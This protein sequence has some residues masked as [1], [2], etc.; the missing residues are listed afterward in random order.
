MGR[1]LVLK[2]FEHAVFQAVAQLFEAL[3][4]AVLPHQVEYSDDEIRQDC[5]SIVPTFHFEIRRRWLFHFQ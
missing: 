2:S 5:L 3:E 1:P 4:A